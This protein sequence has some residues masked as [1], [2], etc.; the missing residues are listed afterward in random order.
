MAH[1]DRNAAI[2]AAIRCELRRADGAQAQSPS[3]ETKWQGPLKS[4][5]L[6]GIPLLN[7]GSMT[8]RSVDSSS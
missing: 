5:Y 3:S 8:I 6:S 1:S 4:K 7:I 2:K